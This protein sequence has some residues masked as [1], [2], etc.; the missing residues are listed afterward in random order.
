MT[1]RRRA[2]KSLQSL[3]SSTSTSAR[4][5]IATAVVLLVVFLLGARYGASRVPRF[6]P[7]SPTTASAFLIPPTPPFYVA[8]HQ[9]PPPSTPPNTNTINNAFSVV[10]EQ[11]IPPIVHYVF[12]MTKDFGN[13][14]FGFI[15]FVAMNSA[16]EN[17]KPQKIMFW[18]LFLP[19]GWWFNKIQEYAAKKGIVFELKKAREVD[20]IL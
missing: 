1:H 3:L 18:Y 13:K 12:G 9:L 8:P 14:P 11:K 7:K 6:D 10:P 4:K 19:S 2:S 17:I 15:Q 5:R 20:E 16:I